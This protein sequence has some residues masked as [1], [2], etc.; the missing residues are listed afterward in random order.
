MLM[1]KLE[2]SS[3]AIAELDPRD[4]HRAL[5]DGALVVDGRSPEA[6]DACHLPGSVNVPMHGGELASRARTAVGGT[7]GAIAVAESDVESLTLALV[8]ERAGCGPVGGILAGGVDAYRAAGHAVGHQHA[9]AAERVVDDLELGGAVLVDARDDED[10]VRG[11]VP[12]SLH[13]PLRSVAAAAPLLPQTPVVV[14]C[15]DGRRAATAATILRRG[16]H[17]NVWRVAGGG[18]PYLL[19]RRLNLGGV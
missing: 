8:L 14:A 19:S 15:T 4:V 3:S 17:A 1:D 10:W 6:Y 18:L 7:P 12:G 13:V 2:N 16:G 9:L 11:H 5:A